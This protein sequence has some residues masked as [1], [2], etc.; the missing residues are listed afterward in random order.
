[1]DYIQMLWKIYWLDGAKYST[2]YSRLFP[3]GFCYSQ[4]FVDFSAQNLNNTYWGQN[5]QFWL[6]EMSFFFFFSLN[7]ITDDISDQKKAKNWMF[8]FF[9]LKNSNFST[10]IKWKPIYPP[11]LLALLVRM[12]K[13]SNRKGL[14]KI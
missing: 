8:L 6:R 10:E 1:M 3:V 13:S 4:N 7:S 2:F 14:L 11:F 9:P 5:R 12:L